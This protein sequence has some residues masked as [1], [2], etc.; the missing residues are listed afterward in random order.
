M[1]AA[2]KALAIEGGASTVTVAVLLTVPGPLSVEETGPVVL[3]SAPGAVPVTL[4]LKVQ[5]ALAASVPPERTM[6]PEFDEAAT[7]PAPQAPVSPLG[8]LTTRPAGRLSIKATP[9]SGKVFGLVMVKVSEVE[10][11][12]RM[13]AAP[14]ALVMVGG[15]ATLMFAVAALPAPPLVELTVPVVLVKLP[16]AAPVTVTLNTHGV[17][18]AMVAPA[19]AMA[20][21]VVVVSVP[22]Q[23]VAE[24][25]AIVRPVGSVSE[26]ATPV[27]AAGLAA[28][29]VMVKVSSVVPFNGMAA[30]LKVLA[31]AGG[32]S[33]LML[34]EAVAPLAPSVEVT[35][36]VVLFCAPAAVP[37]TLTLKVHELLCARVAP[38]RLMRLVACTAMIV[39]PPQV[40]TR[41]LGVEM[42]SPPGN[43]SVKPIPESE[44]V[45]L[46]FWMVKLSEVEPFSGMLAAP[47]VLVMTGG[48]STVTVALEVLPAPPSVELT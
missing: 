13:A 35:A 48:A 29:L 19:R 40:P 2:P 34:A 17:L 36:L 41:V 12:S 30:G 47:K 8:V 26:K 10:A 18:T 3:A 37:V 44:V 16:A 33:T 7:A 11:F 38:E 5:E 39:P 46:L 9:E 31:M 22:P 6:L 45:V 14:K 23:T 32:A 42:M 43:V 21:G 4:T 28:G 15:A 24:E 27:R 25:V 20:V 1:L